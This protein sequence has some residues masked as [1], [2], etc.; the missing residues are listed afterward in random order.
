MKTPFWLIELQ[1]LFLLERVHGFALS[2]SVLFEHEP[3]VVCLRDGECPAFTIAGDLHAE[4]QRDLSHVRCSK[5]ARWLF[6]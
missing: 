4:Y 2:L 1:L 6:L 3:G 5:A